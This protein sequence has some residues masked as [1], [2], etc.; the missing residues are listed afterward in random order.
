MKKNNQLI[1]ILINIILPL[2]ILTKFSEE[3]YLGPLWG[4]IIA[5]AFPLFWGLYELLIQKVKSIISIVGFVGTL[6]TGIIGLMQFPPQWYAVKEAAIP[7]L[8]GL[9]VLISTKKPW[10][11]VTKLIYNREFF[12][13]DKIED[14][15]SLNGSHEQLEKVLNRANRLLSYSFF[16]SAILNYFLAKIIVHSMPGTTQFNEEIGKMT[17]FSYLIITLPSALF[18]VLIFKHILSSIENFTQFN[19]NEL[20]SDKLGSK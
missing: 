13:I 11:L 4:L 19:I 3:G 7:L 12:N 1:S 14:R 9:I 10:R 2:I 15:L 8:I 17:M 20:L 6:L 5:L 16:F 18:I